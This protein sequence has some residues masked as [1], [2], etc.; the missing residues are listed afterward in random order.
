MGG[1]VSSRYWN[2]LVMPNRDGKY[3]RFI[4]RAYPK[5]SMYISKCIE[6][7][8]CPICHKRFKTKYALYKHLHHSSTCRK[9]LYTLIDLIR[10]HV[11]EKELLREIEPLMEIRAVV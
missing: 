5:I 11:P 7:H 9:V 2:A 10:R 8:E 3:K 1:A 4:M 6:Q